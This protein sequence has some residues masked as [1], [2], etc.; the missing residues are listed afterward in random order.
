M[1]QIQ[2]KNLSKTYLDVEALKNININISEGILFGILGPN[3]AGKTTLLKI[4]ATLISPDDGSIFINKIDVKKEPKQIR[5]LIGYVAQEIALDKILTGRELLDFQAD[6]YHI[7]KSKKLERIELLIQQLDMQKW[8]DRKCGTYSG[9]MKRRIDLAAG[10]LHL[11]KV[12]ILDEPTVGLDIESRNIIWELLDSLKRDGMTII[13]SSH[14]LNEIDKLADKVV[15]IN[16][17]QVIDQGNPTQLKNK[18]GG[19]RVSLKVREFSSLEE[20]DKI[21]KILEK[22]EGI[23]QVVINSSQ[24]YSLNFIAER[25]KDLLTKLKVELAFSKFEIFSISQSQ[26]S[27]DD[28]YLQATGKTLQ[29]AEIYMTGKRDLKKESKQSMR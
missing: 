27:L 21:K 3:G 26:P 11:P 24:G 12:L 6:L 1:N 14:Y 7:E 23:S 29:D 10:L 28:V 13:L 4:L 20:S 19:D 18:L 15:I 25:G 22:I 2:I 5:E 9:G 17:G 16:D 8:I